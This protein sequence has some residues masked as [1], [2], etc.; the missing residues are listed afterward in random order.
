MILYKFKVVID[1]SLRKKHILF[2]VSNEDCNL[3]SS[4][5]Y[6]LKD[7]EPHLKTTL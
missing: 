1:P 6:K 2:Y 4:S 7:I 3:F 5:V